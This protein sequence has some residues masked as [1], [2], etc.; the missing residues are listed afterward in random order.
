MSFPALLAPIFLILISKSKYNAKVLE[1]FRTQKYTNS[2]LGLYEHN[3]YTSEESAATREIIKLKIIHSPKIFLSLLVCF[4]IFLA[5]VSILLDKIICKGWITD[6]KCAFEEIGIPILSAAFMLIPFLGSI[7][8]IYTHCIEHNHVQKP[9]MRKYA[10]LAL[11]L[12]TTPCILAGLIE[13]AYHRFWYN[14]ESEIKIF[15]YLLTNI[16]FLLHFYVLFG[17]YLV[18]I[19]RLE[20]KKNSSSS[21][22][23]SLEDIL[24]NEISRSFFQAFLVETLCVENLIFIQHLKQFKASNELQK[25][26]FAKK[27]YRYFIREGSIAQINIS[28]KA[29]K[30]ITENINNQSISFDVFEEAEEEIMFLLTYDSLRK[31]RV[32]PYYAQVVNRFLS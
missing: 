6:E 9:W 8:I 12:A 11:A 18:Q 31:F 28:S 17:S 21:N 1:Y 10:L 15:P 23:L 16:A 20:D 4:W 32:S 24:E 7:Q 3:Q 2:T 13:I 25:E 26:N 22:D 19:Y 14:E 27:I 29:R 5:L 30:T